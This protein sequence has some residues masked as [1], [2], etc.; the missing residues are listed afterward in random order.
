MAQAY[1]PYA[2]GGAP[3]YPGYGSYPQQ[4]QQYGQYGQA[5]TPVAPPVLGSDQQMGGYTPP[6]GYGTQAYGQGGWQQPGP[7]KTVDLNTMNVQPPQET[8]GLDMSTEQPP[9]ETLDTSASYAS[10]TGEPEEPLTPA[11][12]PPQETYPTPDWLQSPAVRPEPSESQEPEA[13]TGGSD[14]GS[15]DP[16]AQQPPR[17]EHER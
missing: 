9:Q 13:G 12:P 5:T 15:D 3:V 6:P 4:G 2:Q 11:Y 10:E 7:Q 8:R 1:N 16:G 17:G 14:T